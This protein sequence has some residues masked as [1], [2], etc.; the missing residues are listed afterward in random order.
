MST[1]L[2]DISKQLK[3]FLSSTSTSILLKESNGISGISIIE[4]HIEKRRIALDTAGIIHLH[5]RTDQDFNCLNIIHVAVA[6][7]NRRKGLFNDFL[8]LME[9]FEYDPYLESCPEITIRIDKVMNPVLDECL[10]KKGY[11]RV[12]S[13]NDPHYSYQKLVWRS[14]GTDSR[15]TSNTGNEAELPAAEVTSGQKVIYLT[16]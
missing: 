16:H 9:G 15:P 8:A 3:A 14:S 11:A 10:P 2:I 4:A 5:G 13:A 12:R 7:R 6:E 1:K